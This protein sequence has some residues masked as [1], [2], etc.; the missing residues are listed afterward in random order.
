MAPQ[1]GAA[2]AWS[3]VMK[4]TSG[5]I[6]LAST[7]WRAMA[8]RTAVFGGVRGVAEA[9]GRAKVETTARG[10]ASR[11]IRGAVPSVV[12]LVAWTSLTPPPTGVKAE[13][14]GVVRG[15]L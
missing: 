7:C 14:E 11:L 6:G 13:V 5:V 15:R 1:N 2:S 10:G 9:R 12:M 3:S 4:S 8:S